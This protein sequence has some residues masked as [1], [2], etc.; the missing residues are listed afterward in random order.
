MNTT[1]TYR[2]RRIGIAAAVLSLAFVPLAAQSGST[3][4]GGSRQGPPMGRRAF[5]P[6]PGGGIVLERFDQALAF[7]DEQ[8]TQIHTL[9]TE[10][11]DAL[12]ATVASLMQAQQA[13][14]S[15]VMQTPADDALLQA[16]VAD[17]GALHAQVQLAR[18]QVESKIFQLLTAD[19]QQK[20][21]QLVAQMTQSRRGAPS[22]R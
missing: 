1:T 22:D 14:D 8:R 6:P 5:G 18:A 2:N 11:R 17:V 7:T 4:A 16:R 3:Q 9:L 15:A 21:Q 20:A 19:Q 10:Q 13:L 12:K